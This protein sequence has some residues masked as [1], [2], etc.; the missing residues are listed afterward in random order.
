M[1]KG[2]KHRIVE[3]SGMKNDYFEKAIL[4]IRADKSSA[5][6][7]RLGLEAR[8]AVEKLLP[9]GRR[10]KRFFD[11]IPKWAVLVS[12]SCMLLSLTML[13]YAFFA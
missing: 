10:K 11:D 5:D 13:F 8:A 9:E 12:A 7:G 2:V 3:I 4:F 6:S 1:I